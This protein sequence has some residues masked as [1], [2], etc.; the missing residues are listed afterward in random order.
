MGKTVTVNTVQGIGDIFWVYQKLAPHVDAINLN[1]LVINEGA[2]QVRARAFCGMLPKVA[3][4]EYVHVPLARYHAIARR[5][6]AVAPVIESASAADYAVNARLE[7]GVGLRE[8]D[9]GYA[10]EEFVDLGLPETVEQSDYL[11]AFVAG[12]QNALCWGADR[13]VD[14]I[15][16]IARHIGTKRIALIGAAWDLAV[17]ESIGAKLRRIG[18]EVESHVGTMELADS[19]D[20]IRRAQFFIGYQSGLNVLA[21]NYDVRQL[22][23]YYKSLEPMMYTWCKRENIGSRYHAMTFAQ[24]I[25]D[26]TVV[27]DD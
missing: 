25:A 22:M 20:V 13:W 6:Y 2:I 26:F 16:K 10:I 1:I 23:I 21:D 8:I 14:A 17:Q 9:P 18:Y 4:V 3:K 27:M 15:T 12:A 19:I 11:C 7:Q 24:D 5:R